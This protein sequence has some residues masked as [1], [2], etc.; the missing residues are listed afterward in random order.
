MHWCEIVKIARKV[1][2][3]NQETIEVAIKL[4]LLVVHR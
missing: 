4:Q 2:P 1:K 3:R